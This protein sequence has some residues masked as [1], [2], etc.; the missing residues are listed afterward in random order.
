M[1]IPTSV[2]VGF[3][4]R[5]D[6]FTGQLAFVTYDEGYGQYHRHSKWEGWRDKSIPVLHEPNRPKS[7]FLLNQDIQRHG[8]L[9]WTARS[10][11]RV[12]DPDG[13]EFEITPNNLLLIMGF[14]DT[15]KKELLGD[16]V[17]AWEGDTLILLPT[18]SDEYIEWK[19]ENP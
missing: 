9:S 4:H 3:Q 2:T 17:Y 6:T 18:A 15:S 10:V 8:S 1:E 11:I 16:C 13:W 14:Y 19:E 12:W 7:G 5:A